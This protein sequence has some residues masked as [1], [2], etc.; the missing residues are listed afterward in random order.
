MFKQRN[1]SFQQNEEFKKH[2]RIILI[3]TPLKFSDVNVK[4]L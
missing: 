2:K 4:L 1:I 3:K